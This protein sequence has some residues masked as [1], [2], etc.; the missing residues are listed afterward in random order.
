MYGELVYDGTEMF[1][2]YNNCDKCGRQLKYPWEKLCTDCEVNE[3][4][5]EINELMDEELHEHEWIDTQTEFN[6]VCGI[7]S[8]IKNNEE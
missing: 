6:E 4:M 7:C 8:K 2:D 5:K 3:E 1:A